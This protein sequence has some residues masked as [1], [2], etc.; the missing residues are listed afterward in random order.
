MVI[1]PT[2]IAPNQP[3]HSQ[4]IIEPIYSA[5]NL[6]SLVIHAQIS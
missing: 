6:V 5:T 3:A 4:Q 2:D 1:Q